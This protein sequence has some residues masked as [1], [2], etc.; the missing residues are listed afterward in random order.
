[1]VVDYDGLEFAPH[2]PQ[3]VRT[4]G[5]AGASLHGTRGQPAGTE[6]LQQVPA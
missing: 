1:M 4:G 2:Q 5:R 3:P 6:R